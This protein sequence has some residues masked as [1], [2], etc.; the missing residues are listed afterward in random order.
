MY[1]DQV[2][3]GQRLKE[4]RRE[5]EMSQEEVGEELGVSEMHYKHIENGHKGIS[6]DLLIDLA[7]LFHVSTDYLLTGSSMDR[8]KE[9]AQLKDVID[10]LTRI[11]RSM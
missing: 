5:R 6:I 4:L 11:T 10:V 2:A 7:E 1:F 8:E 9:T 3:F